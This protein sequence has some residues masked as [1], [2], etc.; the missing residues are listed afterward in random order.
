[1]LQVTTFAKARR[2][3][4]VLLLAALAA[5][6]RQEDAAPAAAPATAPAA[7]APAAPPVSAKV[8]SMG[9][10]QLHASAS[11]ALRENRMYAPAGNNAVEY[12]LALRDKQPDDAGVKSALTDLM[13]YTLIAAEQ[14]INREDFAEA[15]RL[16]ALIEK[17]DSQAPALPR[18]KLGVSNGMHSA[19]QR[20]QEETDKVKKEAEQKARLLAEQQK[21]AQQQASEAQAAQQIAAQQEAARR[22]SARQE[23]ERQA[24]AARSAP[25][26]TPAAA[27][28]A[29]TPAAAAASPQSLRAI[30]TPAPRYPPDALRSGTAGEVLVEITVGTD[31][32][33]TSARVLRAT[34]PRVFDRE[35][36]NATKRWRFEPVSAPVTTR[37]TLAFNPGG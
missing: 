20:S 16:V 23:A 32:S 1:M 36:L 7:T 5:C 21:Q 8:Q 9:T 26:P 34:P 27:P 33:V 2:V 12:Y 35:A 6:S 22:E 15:Q 30:S 10:E 14:S 24:A 19:A 37:R 13:P 28:P 18:L 29:A 17:I 11:Q 4:P 3:A 25:T 31:G